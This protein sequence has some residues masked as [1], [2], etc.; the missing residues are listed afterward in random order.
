MSLEKRLQPLLRGSTGFSYPGRRMLL[1]EV[2]LRAWAEKLQVCQSFQI[3][4]R[5]GY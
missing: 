2:R 4:G 3:C 1:R 5:H